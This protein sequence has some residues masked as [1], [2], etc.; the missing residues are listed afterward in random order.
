MIMTKPNLID[1]HGV[2][3]EKG[4]RGT[5]RRWKKFDDMFRRINTADSRGVVGRVMLQRACIK[6]HATYWLKKFCSRRVT[7]MRTLCT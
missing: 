3:P 6:L 5:A 1:R 2:F 7:C 4:E